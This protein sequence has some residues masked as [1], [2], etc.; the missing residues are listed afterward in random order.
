[1]PERQQDRPSEMIGISFFT[2]KQNSTY[3]SDVGINRRD[4]PRNQGRLKWNQGDSSD[5]FHF[6]SF[7]PDSK[8]NCPVFITTLIARKGYP[9]ISGW[10][11]TAHPVSSTGI[12]T[13]SGVSVF[14]GGSRAVSSSHNPKCLSI[15][16]MIGPSVMN[17]I[18]F[19]GPMHAGHINGSSFQIFLIQSHHVR[20]GTY[21]RRRSPLIYHQFT[22]S[23]TSVHLWLFLSLEY[24]FRFRT[25]ADSVH[26]GGKLR[27]SMKP[28]HAKLTV[29]S[30]H[31]KSLIG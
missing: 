31:T 7:S 16:W 28:R 13:I 24:Q 30:S 25:H 15:L 11:G 14:S 8:H 4:L 22:S 9:I 19:M 10:S 17:A 3:F 5:R 1:M 20:D 27:Y 6:E 18:I 23:S 2:I 12:H 29:N 21:Q 26:G